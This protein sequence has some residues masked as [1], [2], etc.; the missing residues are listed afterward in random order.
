MMASYSASRSFRTGNLTKLELGEAQ[1]APALRRTH[2]RAEHELEHGLLAEAV[3]DDLEPPPL[4]AEEALQKIRRAGRAPVRH[5]KPQVGDTGLEVVL[6]AGDRARQHRP[7]VR[8]HALRQLAR[9][10]A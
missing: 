3:R 8:S 1:A 9:D 2:K 5:R 7:V 10:G 6:K 4:L